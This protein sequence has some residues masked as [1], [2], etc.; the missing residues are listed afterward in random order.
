MVG[1]TIR[2]RTRRANSSEFSIARNR[3]HRG[4]LGFYDFENESAGVAL[5]NRTVG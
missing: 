2:T 5:L 4:D 3:P 1:V